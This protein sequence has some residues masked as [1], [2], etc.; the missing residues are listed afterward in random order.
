MAELTC[1]TY[2]LRDLGIH[3]RILLFY[4]VIILVLFIWLN[5]I[6]YAHPKHIELEFSLC[7]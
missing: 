4:F 2:L 1:L 7:L 6:F 5:P 3:L